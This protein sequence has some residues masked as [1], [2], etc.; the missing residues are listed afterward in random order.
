[1]Q[2]LID[3][4][5]RTHNYLRLSLTH[6]CN[7]NCTY[8]MP[9]ENSELYP[10]KAIMDLEEIDAIVGVFCDFG[11]NKIRLTG[12]EPLIRKDAAE[13]ISRLSRYPV[14]LS[15]TTNG[16]R[17]HCFIDS[18]KK[19]N[20]KSVNISLDSLKEDRF[21]FITKSYLFKQVWNNI[22]LMLKS[23]FSIKINM[24]VISG[25]NDDEIIDFVDLTRKSTIEVRFIEFMPFAGNDWESKNVMS[26]AAILDRIS[27]V[28]SF[29]PKP[30]TINDAAEHFQV[31]GFA[32][33]FATISTM[34]HPF[35]SGCNR[36]RLTA[37]GK[38]KNCLFSKDETDI[39]T[40]FR[41]GMN[42]LPLIQQSISDKAASTGGQFS[43]DMESIQPSS[44]LNRSMIN[45]GG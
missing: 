45:I 13:I 5:G 19:A 39:L 28:Y 37:D 4:F 34:S 17:L 36:I 26:R 24:V 33:S 23:G 27:S 18:L 7:F 14:A 42:I 6:H 16:T 10:S 29:L 43:T 41:K 2:T 21:L 8:C 35:C 40:P 20:V 31:P 12:G 22:Q 30:G 44:L 11:I 38:I 32:G 3:S 15:L 1:M 9:H 25:I